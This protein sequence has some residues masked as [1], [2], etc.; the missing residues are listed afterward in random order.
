MSIRRSL[1]LVVAVAALAATVACEKKQDTQPPAPAAQ[2]AD[3][4]K[5]PTGVRVEPATLTVFAELPTQFGEP[6][7]EEVWRLGQQLYF[8]K[9]LSKNHDISCNSCHD[10]AK[11][12]VDGS[13]TSTGHKQ[14][15]GGR[16]APTVYNAAGHVAQFWDG[17][18]KDVEEQALGPI[19]NPI[20]MAL[21]DQDAALRVLRSMPGYVAAF[22]RA[23]GEDGVTWENVGAAIGAY[24]RKLVTP[25][26]FDRF[27][28]GDDKAL[29]D[30]QKRGLNTFVQTGCTACH[31][32]ALLGGTSYQKVG[33]AAPWPA[34]TDRG[35]VE[36]TGNASDENVFKVPSL[37]NITETGPYFHDGKTVALDDAVV[38]MARYQLGRELPPADVQDIVSFLGA[39]KGELPSALIREPELPPSTSETPAPDAS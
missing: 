2:V 37:R 38:L 36:V 13:P 7:P 35:R 18:A 19:L 29:T 9:R 12:G 11:Y 39:L 25:A 21:P 30:A 5:E 4:A 6:A 24:E 3:V 20:E 17:R 10:V 34:L 26:P 15:V 32:G 14:Q 8:D 28:A 16:N 23:F 22:E 1:L 27:L 31:N 33:A